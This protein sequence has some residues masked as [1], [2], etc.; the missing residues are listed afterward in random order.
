MLN[1]ILL[2]SCKEQN[3]T[4]EWYAKLPTIFHPFEA[5]PGILNFNWLRLNLKPLSYE[6]AF[7]KP[8][9]QI[10]Y[11]HVYISF[12]STEPYMVSIL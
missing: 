10:H 7:E 8:Y 4:W 3:R 2:I 9:A 5:S 11:S 6:F 12:Q 1:S